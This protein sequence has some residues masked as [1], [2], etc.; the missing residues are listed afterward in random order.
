MSQ[1]LTAPFFS[2]LRVSLAPATQPGRAPATRPGRASPARRGPARW[3]MRNVVFTGVLMAFDSAAHLTDRFEQARR[4][5]IEMFPSQRRPGR[6][7]QGFIQAQ[8]RL[9]PGLQDQVRAHLRGVHQRVAGVSWRVCGWLAMAADGSRVETPRTAANER[10]LGCAGRDKTGPQIALTTLYHMGTGL[11]WAWTFGPGTDA[12][13]VHL[14]ALLSTLPPRTLLVADAGFTGFDLLQ[15]IV[16]GGHSYLIRVGSNVR[17]LTDLLADADP[18]LQMRREGQIVWLWPQKRR[19][20]RPL[21]LRLIRLTRPAGAARDMYLLTNVLSPQQLPDDTAARLYQLRWGVE[22]LYR[23]FKQTLAHRKLRS[24]APQ[25]AQWELDWGMIGLLL[26]GLMSLD[27]AGPGAPPDPQGLSVA[28]ALRV[29]RRAMTTR[30]AWRRRG[31]LRVLLAGAVKDAY[32]RTGPKKARDWP[33]KK[34]ERPPGAPQIRAAS[35][36]ERERATRVCAAA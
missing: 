7:Y 13:R 20:Q 34:R 17:L 33:H 30:D 14:M 24:A 3:S 25:Q 26:L 5:L 2:A 9:P 32:A 10:V 19:D 18:D 35:R 4:C 11:P 8:K 6:S 28:A 12:E 21:R 23:G 1:H 31:D 36:A 27:A 16:A 22:L 15:A 29:V